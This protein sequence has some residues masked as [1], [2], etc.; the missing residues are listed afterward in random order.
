MTLL[1]LDTETYCETPIN[2]GTHRYAEDAEVMII[3]Y[4]FNDGATQHI[5]LTENDVPLHLYA[6]LDDPD[7]TIVMHNAAF[8]RTILR[9]ALG[10][11]IPIERVHCTMAQALAHGLPGS[12]GVLGE[13]FGVPQDQMKDKKGR[14]LVQL[15][16][17]P[18]PKNHKLRRATSQTHPAEWEQFIDYAKQDIEAMRS[19]YKRL[20]KWNYRGD[21]LALWQLDQKINDRG[22]T[23][24]LDLARAA[25]RA[26]KD[27]KDDL[28]ERTRQETFYTITSTNRRDLLL[29]FI[30]DEY[31]VKLEDMQMSTLEKRMNDP[32]MPEGLR[33][34]LAIRLQASTTSAAKYQKL[35]NAVS[36]DGRL[37]GTLQFCGA[38]RTGRWAGRVFQPQNLPRPSISPE[39]VDI[40]IDAMKHGVE[41]VVFSN[42]MEMVS[43]AI[44]GCLVA[45]PGKK[46]VVSDLANIEGRV[47]AWLAGEERKLDAFRAYDN[48]TGPDL[49]KLAYAHAFGIPVDQVTKDQR[50]IGKV[51]ELFMQYEGG[52]GAF[53]TGA[54]SYG[55]DLDAMADA[56]WESIPSDIIKEAQAAWEWAEKKNRTLGLSEKTY[57]VCD[58]L[59][60]MWRRAH[61]NI[62]ALWAELKDTV[63]SAI[64]DDGK[65]FQCGKLLIMKKGA[66]LRIQLPSGR[67]LCYAAPKIENSTISY[68]GINQYTRQW[69]YQWSY[70]GK[71]FENICQAVARDVMA[72]NMPLIERYGYNIVLSVH[73]ELI[74]EA[75]D[76]SKFGHH[77]LSMALSANPHWASDLPLAAGGF[78]SYR[79][80]KE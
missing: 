63:M 56:A 23:V 13:V 1:F 65:Q 2:A 55:I 17:K 57:K 3:T 18:R 31:G 12:L 34:L 30:L 27:A 20:P 76:T 40:G 4:A 59:K 37:R 50:Q 79:Y 43:S 7:T 64:N 58:S 21:E 67:Y 77:G 19:L 32:E 51:L 78:E 15:F 62:T 41:S 52:V 75:P 68:M 24:D 70:G 45:A 60:R 54:M 42:V 74:T 73:D 25:V 36:N 71:I 26:I 29:K 6:R 44:R 10:I 38:S 48:G 39:M 61:P 46:L 35:I 53:I 72:A 47:A 8:D 5:D 28:E 66:W 49:Y 11:D 14:E 69:S 16:C 9:H 22:I 33:S 80:K